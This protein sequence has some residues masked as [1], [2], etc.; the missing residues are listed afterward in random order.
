MSAVIRRLKALWEKLLPST[1]RLEHFWV[2][3]Q[4]EAPTDLMMKRVFKGRIQ[5]A[6]WNPSVPQ[7][8]VWSLHERAN[9]RHRDGCICHL[10]EIL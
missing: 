6:V 1:Y 2:I 3:H 9:G 4:A 8:E 5:C 7:L 10:T